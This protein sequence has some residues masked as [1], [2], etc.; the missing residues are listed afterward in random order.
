MRLRLAALALTLLVACTD[1]DNV[2]WVIVS[3]P[4]GGTVPVQGGLVISW[5]NTSSSSKSFFI[6]TGL[7]EANH[8]VAL[9]LDETGGPRGDDPTQQRT[10]YLG[11]DN[12]LLLI[13]AADGIEIHSPAMPSGKAEIP[14]GATVLPGP[15]SATALLLT[16]A[17]ATL[18]F[19]A[20]GNVV[21]RASAGSILVMRPDLPPQEFP[22]GSTIEPAGKDYIIVQPGGRRTLISVPPSIAIGGQTEFDATRGS[23]RFFS[24]TR[25]LSAE[26][27]A[28]R[29]QVHGG[30][31]GIRMD[32]EFPSA[33][34]GALDSPFRAVLA[35]RNHHLLLIRR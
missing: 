21:L 1:S 23:Y 11:I 26:L 32:G 13:L 31:G 34:G 30:S 5:R 6:V 4:S 12:D 27:P 14:G 29:F 20:A 8:P 17:E 7:S 10:I 28:N 9:R 16:S 35:P 22:Q 19:A 18:H 3:N 15:D 2:S 25:Q 33:A 24:Y